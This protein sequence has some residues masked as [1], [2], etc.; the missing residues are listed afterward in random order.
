[1]EQGRAVGGVVR[2]FTTL[3]PS[4]GSVRGLLHIFPRGRIRNTLIKSHDD[5]GPERLLYR[6]GGFWCQHMR[7]T[8]EVRLKSDPLFGNFSQIPQTENLKSPTISQNRLVPVHKGMET[9]KASDQF[10]PGT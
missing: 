10:M 8:I 3:R 7:R 2:F 6:N 5:V 1:A 9:P 4:T